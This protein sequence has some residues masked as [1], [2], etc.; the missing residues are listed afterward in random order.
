M[1]F[2]FIPTTG[3]KKMK[4]SIEPIRS[5]RMRKE[6]C[7]YNILNFLKGSK[8]ILTWDKGKIIKRLRV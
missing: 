2:N 8:I 5:Q 6:K 4:I 1:T 3:G 7:F